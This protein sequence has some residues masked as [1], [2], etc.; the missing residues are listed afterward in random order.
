MRELENCIERA[1]LL[2]DDEVIRGHHLP[3][4]LQTADATGTTHPGTL[5]A[6][7]EHL[8]REL[9]ID[10]LKLHRGNRAAAARSLGL[11]ERII[12]LRI[13]KYGIEPT[14]YKNPKTSTLA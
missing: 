5:K 2:T 7:L 6:A 4:T 10:A 9:I 3:P 14:R 8:E 1:V 11:T 12:G 13:G